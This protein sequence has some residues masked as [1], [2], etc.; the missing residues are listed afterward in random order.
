MINIH[1]LVILFVPLMKT[2]LLVTHGVHWLPMVDSIIVLKDGAISESGSYEELLSYNGDFSEFLQQYLQQDDTD[3]DEDPESKT[4]RKHLR[5]E[6]TPD[7]HL[8]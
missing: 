3:S 7:F 6:V 5:T 4:S 8:T 2:R 1:I